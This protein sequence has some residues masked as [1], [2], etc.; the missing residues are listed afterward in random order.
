MRLSC[1][2]A[3]G[4]ML[5]AV[6]AMAQE[7][8]TKLIAGSYYCSQKVP[9]DRRQLSDFEWAKV[10]DACILE[11]FGLSNPKGIIDNAAGLD[12]SNN[13]TTKPDS[14][15][16]GQ[17]PLLLPKCSVKKRENDVCII[18]CLLEQQ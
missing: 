8:G 2:T 18:H 16:K 12:L 10:G 3:L 15:H 17:G 5:M 4:L 13:F 6:P 9:C 11:A 1:V 7:N 14:V